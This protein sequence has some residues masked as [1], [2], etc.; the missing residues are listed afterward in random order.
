M[1]V[2][3]AAV[4]MVGKSR[5]EILRLRLSH[6]VSR[7]PFH[8]V[9]KQH[10][11]VLETGEPLAFETCFNNHYL[12]LTVFRVNNCTLAFTGLDITER[13]RA[14]EELKRKHEE[15]N[16]ALIDKE[17]LLS[18]IHHRLKNNLTAFISLIGLE[19]SCDETP[20]GVEMRKNLQNRARSM[21]LIHETLYRTNTYSSVD[22]EVYLSA[23]VSQI[24]ASY[25]GETKVRAI[26]DAHGVTLDLSRA[27]ASGMI[28]NE[29]LTNSLK[30]AFPPSRYCNGQKD[31]PLEIH[32]DLVLLGEE[33]L[34]TIQD[35]GIGLPG[36]IDIKT[37]N[38]LGLKL[39]RFLAR[40]Q[41]RATIG[42][43]PC[44]GTA[45]RF[46]FRD[47]VK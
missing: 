44:Q 22:M 11:H 13:R 29:L 45:F 25:G 5:E 24:I 17:V 12:L 14:E 40:H 28:V 23:L 42:V 31:A 36:A 19:G 2:N 27:A 8:E 34:L 15:L 26:V 39:V 21:A 38:T 37:A 43:V 41:L 4:S 9:L 32:I 3:K 1:S 16:K 10:V 46:A 6:V 20:E 18:E 47:D 30:Y 7:G 33:Y 35:N